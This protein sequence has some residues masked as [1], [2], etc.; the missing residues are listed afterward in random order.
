M[1]NN[2]LLEDDDNLDDVNDTS[3]EIDV[4]DEVIEKM[5]STINIDARRRVEDYR[6]Q[7]EL[8]RLLNDEF[9]YLD[10]IA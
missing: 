8:E 5:K 6:D 1:G 9:D 7:R 4:E 2:D 3:T 10:D